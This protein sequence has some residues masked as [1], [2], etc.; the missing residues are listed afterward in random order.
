[1]D[2]LS[3][4]EQDS[5]LETRGVQATGQVNSTDSY[6]CRFYGKSNGNDDGSIPGETDVQTTHSDDQLST[7][8]GMQL[9]GPDFHQ[10]S[11]TGRTPMVEEPPVQVERAIIHPPSDGRGCLHGLIRQPLGLSRQRGHHERDLDD[12]GM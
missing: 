8:D 2:T 3:P 7:E 10:H 6:H 4:Q 9:D 5:R 11:G 12:T 1:H